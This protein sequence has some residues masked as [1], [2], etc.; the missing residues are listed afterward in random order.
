MEDDSSG[1]YNKTL[2]TVI[3]SK[4][5]VETAVSSVK[6]VMSDFPSEHSGL[7]FTVP[8]DNV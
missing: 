2:F 3:E 6:E 5:L 4:E 7:M 1:P 8:I